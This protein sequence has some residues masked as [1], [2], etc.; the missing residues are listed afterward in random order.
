M[1]QVIPG[2][3]T[4]RS[5]QHWLCFFTKAITIFR[6]RGKHRDDA[7]EATGRNTV[8]AHLP[9]KTSGYEVVKLIVFA[10][11][12]ISFCGSI[13][14]GSTGSFWL[15]TLQSPNKGGYRSCY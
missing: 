9:I 4:M 1:M 14:A 6:K 8:N 5:V 13:T 7:Q 15:T 10:R 12:Y 11:C 2:Y 3:F